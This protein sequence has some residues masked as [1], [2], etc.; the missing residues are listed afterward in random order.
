MHLLLEC[1]P[2]SIIAEYRLLHELALLP[3]KNRVVQ[4]NP[5]NL[6]KEGVILTEPASS[7]L[8]IPQLVEALSANVG[9]I[10]CLWAVAL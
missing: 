3:S 5:L 2:D 6:G 7:Y 4:H 1:S 9:P 8:L 10:S